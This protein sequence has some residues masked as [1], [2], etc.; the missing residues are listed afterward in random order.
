MTE[1]KAPRAARPHVYTEKDRERDRANGKLGG[2]ATAAR[3]T[4]SYYAEIGRKGGKATAARG[5]DHLRE[6]G[7]K[8]ASALRARLG[9]E[10][11]KARMRELAAAGARARWTRN[12]GSGA[13][14]HGGAP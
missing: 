3:R 4:G 6:T 5:A 10:G 9:E 1:T 2:A 8:G 14:P 11:Y 7:A 12:G 13:P